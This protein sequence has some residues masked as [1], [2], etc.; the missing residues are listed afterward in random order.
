M[1]VG[2]DS[3]TEVDVWKEETRRSDAGL[4]EGTGNL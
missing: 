4:P 3:G 1:C 2:M